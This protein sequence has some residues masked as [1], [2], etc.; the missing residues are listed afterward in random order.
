MSHRRPC[1]LIAHRVEK[2]ILPQYGRDFL[3][4]QDQQHTAPDAEKEIV[5]LEEQ[6][7]FEGLLR[8][9]DFS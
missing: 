8:L 6:A 5:Q 9:H 4:H 3:H 7:H 1:P 2:A